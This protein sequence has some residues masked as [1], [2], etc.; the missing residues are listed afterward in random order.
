MP[1]DPAHPEGPSNLLLHGT[2]PQC[3]P[4]DGR[5]A[6]QPVERG[7]LITQSELAGHGWKSR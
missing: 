4:D 7:H 6:M 3:R 5:M 2:D 1:I